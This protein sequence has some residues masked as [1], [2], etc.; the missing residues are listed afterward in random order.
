MFRTASIANSAIM[1]RT[2]NER[3]IRC[4]SIRTSAESLGNFEQTGRVGF[5]GSVSSSARFEDES[6]GGFLTDD[7]ERSRALRPFVDSRAGRYG[8][9]ANAHS[10]TRLQRR[11]PELY[12]KYN[13]IVHQAFRVYLDHPVTSTAAI[14][15]I[16]RDH[17]GCSARAKRR[18]LP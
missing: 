5:R 12:G 17:A 11:V 16:D 4:R 10:C 6:R 8:P 14:L 3:P 15:T 7:L 2:G 13:P 1:A 9:G 18:I